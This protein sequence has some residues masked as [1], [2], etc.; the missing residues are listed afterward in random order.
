MTDVDEPLKST[1]SSGT[2]GVHASLMVALEHPSGTVRARAVQQLSKAV[3]EAAGAVGRNDESL[4]GE[5]THH[6]CALSVFSVDVGCCTEILDYSN[7]WNFLSFVEVDCG[8]G[9][10]KRLS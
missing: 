9:T 1:D 2:A 4:G 6:V 5:K 7:W 10:T 3:S 8:N